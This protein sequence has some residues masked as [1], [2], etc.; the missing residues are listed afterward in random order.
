MKA[1]LIDPF[2]RT[3]EDVETDASLEDIYRL[4]G[5][6][7]LD[8]VYVDRS[9]TMFIDDEGLLKNYFDENDNQQ[10][11][12]FKIGSSQTYAGKGLIL[13]TTSDGDNT[14]TRLSASLI[15]PIVTWVH[16]T[17]TVPPIL[18]YIANHS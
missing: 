2:N 1:I 11:P 17:P 13:G 3:V 10:Y 4:C 18:L 16:E 5:C 14:D 12:Y 6:D 7:L 15:R 8:T 9:H